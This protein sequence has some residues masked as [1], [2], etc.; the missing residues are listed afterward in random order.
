MIR[1]DVTVIIA[2]YNRSEQLEHG[3]KTIFS[4]EV[5]PGSLVIVDDGSTDD[6]IERMKHFPFPQEVKVKYQYLNYPEPRISCIPHNVGIK[7][8]Q[9][10]I[11]IF[12][13]SEAI[14]SENSIQKIVTALEERPNEI[15]LATQ[16]WSM[17]EKFYK[18]IYNGQSL[19]E[20]L[21]HPYAMIVNG[22]MQN[23]A[24]PDSDWSLT[25][26]NN[27][28]AGVLFGCYKKDAIAIG[29]FDE[30]FKDF[31]WDDWDFLHR[32]ELY[33]K[34]VIHRNDIPV[35]HMW[36]EKKYPYN[37]YDAGER[38]GKIS[39]AN[40]HAGIYKVNDGDN[41]GIHD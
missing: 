25:G 10:D 23:T 7:Q 4:Q 15:P 13:E 14:H 9:G 38:N 29:G 36:H 40:I 41:W 3:L 24:A 39:E 2:T 5:I 28:Y 20:L 6:T 11:L 27:C 16:I 32:M 26:S 1:N 18:E 37:I 21:K 35:I 12:T 19:R 8:A 33:G 22:N 17:G 34:T 31:G 30:S